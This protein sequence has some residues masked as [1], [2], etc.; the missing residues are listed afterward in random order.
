MII[1]K[2]IYYKIMHF[3]NKMSYYFGRLYPVDDK[4]IVLES[5]GDFSDNAEALYNY[6]KT[7]G[8]LRTYRVI[9]LVDNPKVFTNTSNNIYISKKSGTI[10]F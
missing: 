9:W 8:F 7:N 10:W 6:M 1:L 4:M 3:S 5:E 2:K